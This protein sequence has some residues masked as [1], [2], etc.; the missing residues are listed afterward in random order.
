MDSHQTYKHRHFRT[1]AGGTKN[2]PISP[3]LLLCFSSFSF[4]PLHYV[5]KIWGRPFKILSHV[6]YKFVLPPKYN[7][8]IL[9]INW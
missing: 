2:K 6:S 9:W 5:E 1:L 7:Y 3:K 4:I 8:T